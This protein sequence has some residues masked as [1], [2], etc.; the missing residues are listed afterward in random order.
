MSRR[1]V[2]E[3]IKGLHEDLRLPTSG[4]KKNDNAAVKAL[5]IFQESQ[6]YDLSTKQVTILRERLLEVARLVGELAQMAA[7]AGRT[8][9]FAQ[10][11]ELFGH[12]AEAL[13]MSETELQSQLLVPQHAN[14]TISNHERVLANH[15]M[16]MRV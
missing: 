13:G 6:E 7:D 3:M 11:M 2:M 12:I 15:K 4:W 8:R 1:H 5:E 10:D 9:H 14:L 16:G